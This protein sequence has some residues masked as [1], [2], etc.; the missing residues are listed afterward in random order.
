MNLT[1]KEERV[2]LN[3]QLEGKSHFMVKARN[4]FNYF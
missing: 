4:A 3:V 1:G 2:S